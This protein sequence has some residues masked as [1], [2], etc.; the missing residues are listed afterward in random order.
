MDKLDEVQK[1][2]YTFCEDLKLSALSLVFKVPQKD[3]VYWNAIKSAHRI[4]DWEIEA[5]RTMLLKLNAACHTKC[6]MLFESSRR[7]K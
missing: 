2:I 1:D 6:N 7:K 3:S 4:E 5:L